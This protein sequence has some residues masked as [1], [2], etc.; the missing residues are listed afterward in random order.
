VKIFKVDY[1]YSPSSAESSIVVAESEEDV[2]EIIKKSNEYHN[3]IES[4][5]EIELIEGFVYTGYSC[6]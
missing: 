5:E 6:C 1:K 3:G 4:I 2:I